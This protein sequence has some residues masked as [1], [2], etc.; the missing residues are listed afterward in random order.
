MSYRTSIISWP[1]RK[2]LSLVAM[3][4]SQVIQKKKLK[5]N[6]FSITKICTCL[7]SKIP[8][9]IKKTNRRSMKKNNT[10]RKRGRRKPGGRAEEGKGMKKCES[11]EMSKGVGAWVDQKKRRKKREKKEK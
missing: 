2:V 1:K 4:E 6:Y 3:Y 7:Y 10:Y 11:E 8:H 9:E 5:T